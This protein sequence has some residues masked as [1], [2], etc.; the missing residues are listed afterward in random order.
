MINK[1]LQDIKKSFGNPTLKSTILGVLLFYQAYFGAGFINSCRNSWYS[2]DVK[3]YNT[4]QEVEQDVKKEKEALGIE[5][6][7]ININ[8]DN[9]F[10]GCRMNK[11]G[12]YTINFEPKRLN[13]LV[14]RHEFYHI[15]KMQEGSLIRYIP[16]I[17]E[18]G[19][20]KATSYAIKRAQEE[21][22]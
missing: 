15:K 7:V 6:L 19:E 22:R 3:N 17:D 1:I 11:D 20:W 9:S 5:N 16:L 2:R 21:R 12:S 10:T 18:Y 8:V 4:L 14:L 13:Y